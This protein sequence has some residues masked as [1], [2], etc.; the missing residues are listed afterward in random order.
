MSA[1]H[2]VVVLTFCAFATNEAHAA[3]V[4]LAN[5]QSVALDLQK[6]R[7]HFDRSEQDH[8][9]SMTNLMQRMTTSSALD[10]LRLNK[11]ATPELLAFA[12]TAVT[13]SRLRASQHAPIKPPTGYDAADGAKFMLNSMLE[14]SMGKYDVEILKCRNFYTAQ[15]G[16][17]E[18]A[19]GKISYSNTKVAQCRTHIL[20]AEAQI[21]AGEE[22]VAPA[23]EALKSHR[24]TCKDDVKVLHKKLSTLQGDIEVMSKILGMT[25][26]GSSLIQTSRHVGKEVGVLH[27]KH[28]C[29]DVSLVTFDHS[30]LKSHIDLLKT[31]VAQQLLQESFSD[32]AGADET[33]VP[34]GNASKLGNTAVPSSPCE[35]GPPKMG[36]KRSAKC[37]ISGTASCTKLEERFILIQSGLK[38][39]EDNMKDNVVDVE[40]D[41]EKTEE[42]L[43]VALEKAEQTLKSYQ[44]KLAEGT[45]CVNEAAEEGRLGNKEFSE[46]TEELHKMKSQCSLNYQTL[47]GEMCG[48]KKIRGELYTK[49]KG[50]GGKPFFQDCK[51]SDWTPGECSVDCA[52]GTM[53]MT[54]AIDTQPQGGAKCLPLSQMRRCNEQPCPVDCRLNTWGG[55][56]S[57]SAECG[58]GVEERMRTVE[59][60]MKH[61]GA[62]CG[63]TSESQACNVQACEADCDLGEW[64]KWSKCSKDCDGGSRK[65]MKH[66][67]TAATGQGECPTPGS[68]DRMQ[69]K[70]CN[71]KACPAPASAESTIQC[72]AKIDLILLLDG[73]GSLGAAG[74]K[75]TKAAAQM[76][77]GAMDK[78]EAQ[79]AVLL[80]SGP[81]TWPMVDK[82]YK[83]PTVNKE[84]ACR[85]KWVQHFSEKNKGMAL[86]KVKFLGWPKGATMTSLALMAA[87]GETQISRKDA[88]SVV[89]V[90]TDGKPLSKRATK[91]ASKAVRKV[92]RLMWVP[93]TNH[94]PLTFIRRM[95]SKPWREN[96]VLASSFATLS[97]PEFINHL[98]AD[99]C[100]V[101]EGADV[102]PLAIAASG[103]K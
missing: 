61:H 44:T 65:R 13:H 6:L 26:C 48:I 99:M 8:A 58:G 91:R 41:C 53:M 57:C 98:I 56:S 22:N 10:I 20:A 15:C 97:K 68:N 76:I 78:D 39:T 75:A 55:W 87:L 103:G 16:Q 7:H 60:L 96:V 95:A 100:P 82:C 73:S 4:T 90:I 102:D 62:P 19:R 3:T 59:R 36:D 52:G 85:I 42:T 45:G 33:W 66:I 72:K 71:V 81:S 37:T 46:L 2:A 79:I 74:W 101:I 67:K 69:F 29:S 25:D 11:K 86:T 51:L 14:E 31:K 12:Q 83:D 88:Q 93:V 54:R 43:S 18:A 1:V 21:D 24:S 64:T 94:A 5:N 34:S 27:C 47:E 35:D 23:K 9:T 70:K 17:V 92:A 38:D 84:V 50:T 40:K 63:E 28:D 49:M 89:V 32:I 30:P 77:I 80:Y